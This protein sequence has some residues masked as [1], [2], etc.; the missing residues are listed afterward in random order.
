MFAAMMAGGSFPAQRLTSNPTVYQPA[1]ADPSFSTEFSAPLGVSSLTINAFAGGGFSALYNPPL[2]FDIGERGGGQGARA[3]G[4]VV[5]AA[6]ND[7]FALSIVP[8]SGRGKRLTLVKNGTTILDLR[9]GFDA[10]SG[11]GAVVPSVAGGAGGTSTVDPGAGASASYL[12]GT[13]YGGQGGWKTGSP[14]WVAYQELQ[15]P[16]YDGSV[17]DGAKYTIANGP[18]GGSGQASTPGYGGT[19][20]L[21]E[22]ISPPSES[23]D[24]IPPNNA[25]ISIAW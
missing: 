11:G 9:G 25:G 7:R 12:S 10:G 23:Y 22:Y 16:D 18:G 21:V 3:S 14:G 15:W 2:S 1:Y 4:I 19:Q 20:V 24:E 6:P 17:I 5:S 13:V 8:E